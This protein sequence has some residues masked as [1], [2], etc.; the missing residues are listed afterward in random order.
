MNA[1]ERP[2]TRRQAFALKEVV[3]GLGTVDQLLEI[4]R[5]NRGM[6]GGD[7]LEGLPQAEL[8]LNAERGALDLHER[9]ELR[10]PVLS[11]LNFTRLAFSVTH[12]PACL[13]RFFEVPIRP[14]S[15]IRVW[16]SSS[17]CGA[18]DRISSPSGVLSF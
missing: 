14:I 13:D 15:P 7:L 1:T 6:L 12:A 16:R 5:G 18:R 4:D 11:P 8:A 17:I 10:L 2:R 3:L 9:A